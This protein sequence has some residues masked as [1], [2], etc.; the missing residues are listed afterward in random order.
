MPGA[1]GAQ[2]VF[3]AS[4]RREALVEWTKQ[5]GPGLYADSRSPQTEHWRRVVETLRTIR[6]VPLPGRDP[7]TTSP[8]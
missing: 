6:C 7:E 3:Q 1:G 8:P 2:R 5:F 4:G